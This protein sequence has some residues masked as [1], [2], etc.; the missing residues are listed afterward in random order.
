MDDLYSRFKH[1]DRSSDSLRVNPRPQPRTPVSRSTS[2]TAPVVAHPTRSSAYQAS[3]PKD[4][5]SQNPNSPKKTSKK[6]KK[7]LTLCLVILLI[8]GIAGAGA[9]Y[10]KKS[11]DNAARLEPKG[12]PAPA[13]PL[14]DADAQQATT[15][16]IRLVATGDMIA[17]DSINK[18]AKQADGK[19]DYVKLMDKMQPYFDK[20]DISFC[21]QSTP[22]GGA[23]FGITGYPV[24]N[25]PIEFAR[26]IEGVGCNL[27]NIGTNHTND[28]GQSLIDATVAAWDKR[29]GILAVAGANR[30]VEEQKKLRTFEVKG[31]KFALL[32]YSTYT[33]KPVTNGFGVNMYDEATAK[34]EI[35]AARKE[36]DFVIVSMRW[37]TEYSTEINSQQSAISQKLAGFGADVILGH[38]PHVLQPVKKLK[39]LDGRETLVWYSLGNFL[40]SQLNIETLVGGFAVMDIDLATK[41]IS[42]ISFLPVYQHYEWTAAEKSSGTAAALMAR[43]NFIMIPLDQAASLLA[44]SQNNTSVKAQ[45]DRVTSVLNKFTSVPIINSAE[46]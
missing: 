21:N 1:R 31:M 5:L 4:Q 25:A 41:K 24:F 39:G 30:S 17:H 15:G 14:T 35:T 43:R 36:V 27:I 28:K 10:Y 6:S 29:D 42:S 45:T 9:F 18:N 8:L 2:R 16:T 37:G 33:N 3:P 20:A 44:K 40:N 12:A 7:I 23:S 46:Y 32:S 26:G 34:N 11:K 13:A 38:G 22:A 19:Y